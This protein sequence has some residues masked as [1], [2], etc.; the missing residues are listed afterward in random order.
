MSP[1]SLL[2]FGELNRRGG[3]TA[4]GERLV[5]QE[6]INASWQPRTQS[7]W[8]GDRHGYAWFLTRI[9]AEEVRY[10][11]GYGGQML[12]I[13]PRLGLTVVMTSDERASAARSGHRSD[14]HRLLG[15]IISA[16]ANAAGT[17]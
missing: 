7:P 13:V 15:Q 10:G 6:W 4:T 8:T 12:Y 3:V 14:L 2:A 1:R 11:W 5:S 17:S 9:A 16:T